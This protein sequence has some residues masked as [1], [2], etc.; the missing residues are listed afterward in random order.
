MKKSI[1][2]TNGE[3]RMVIPP[4]DAASEEQHLTIKAPRL[5]VASFKIMGEAPY[6]QNRFSQKSLN[7]M[8]DTQKEGSTTRGKKKR[9]PKDFDAAYEGALYRPKAGGYGIPAAAF[10]LAMID[11]CRTV[12]YKMTHAKLAAFVIA[13]DFDEIDG[14]PLVKL[15][16]TPRKHTMHARNSDGSTDVRTRPLWEDW[17]A[18]VRVRYDADM[19]NESDITNLMMRVGLQV[20]VG[21]GR[22]YSKNSAGL[23]FGTFTLDGEIKVGKHGH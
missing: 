13:D 8:I 16:G 17:H 10:R 23:G 19:F 1:A 5:Y 20:G 22:P 21:E 3:S 12:G 9:E 4:L 15:Y 6:M 7:T 11:A 18:V 2:G 14:T